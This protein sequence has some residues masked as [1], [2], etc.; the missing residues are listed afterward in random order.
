MKRIIKISATSFLLMIATILL[1]IMVIV[2]G[3]SSSK[4]KSDAN[5]TLSASVESYRTYVT[6]VA[7][8]EGVEEYVYLILCIMQVESNGTGNDPMQASECPYNTKYPNKPNAITDPLYS[9]ECGV[10]NIK[11]TLKRA[12]VMNADDYE[13]IKV[14]LGGYNF[15]NGFVE[16]LD[17]NHGGKWTL[18]NA[19]EF[20][21]MMANKL[22]WS[23]YGDPPYADKV[24]KYYMS[25]SLEGGASAPMGKEKYSAL[26]KEGEKYL[27]F[28]YVFGGGSPSTSFDCS[29]FVCWVYTH[30]N[31]YNLPRTTAQGIYNQCKKISKEEAKPGDLIFFTGTYDAGE[32]V[33]HIGIYVGNGRMLHCGNPIGYENVEVP[34]WQSHFYAYGRL[35]I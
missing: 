25:S 8:D 19:Q 21:D 22:G 30:A 12:S 5:N 18:E 7:K 33:S 13:R 11:D 35:P 24:M 29:G 32:P 3:A 2:G 34:Y 9:I 26:I 15:G 4:S 17:A 28:P 27:G 31:V 1:L 14:A 16:W 23:A 6:K 20:S 10:K